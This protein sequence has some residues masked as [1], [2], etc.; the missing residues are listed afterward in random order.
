MCKLVHK[1]T[2][3]LKAGPVSFKRMLGDALYN[4][5][6]APCYAPVPVRSL[7]I[8]P[9]LLPERGVGRQA[10]AN[11]VVNKVVGAFGRVDECHRCCRVIRKKCRSYVGARR[12]SA[13]PEN[14]R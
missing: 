5:R 8:Q 2:S 13:S 3:P 10:I 11:V 1:R 6:I 9:V 14:K 12:G 4:A 7:L